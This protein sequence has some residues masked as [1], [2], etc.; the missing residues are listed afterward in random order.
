M[1]KADNY[2]WLVK[3]TSTKR[4]IR[5]SKDDPAGTGTVGPEIF[6]VVLKSLKEMT[7]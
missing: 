4:A 6:A 3:D 7:K 5:L 1:N 2:N